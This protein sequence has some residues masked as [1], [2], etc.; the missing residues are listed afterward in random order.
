MPQFRYGNTNMLVSENAKI[1]I[2]PNAKHKI[3]VTPKAKPLCEPMEYS[4]RWVPNFRIGHVH[5]MLFVLFVLISFALVTQYKLVTNFSRV[6][7]PL[8]TQFAVEYGLKSPI[9]HFL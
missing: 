2:T 7:Y 4:L 1:C 9:S 8:R 5:F 3:C 6:G